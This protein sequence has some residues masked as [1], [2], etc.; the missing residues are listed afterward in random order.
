[1]KKTK[2]KPEAQPLKIYI[3]GSKEPVEC[4]SMFVVIGEST[5]QFESNSIR[6]FVMSVPTKHLMK[7]D[8]QEVLHFK[9]N[10]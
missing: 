10:I 8:E 9:R 5:Y 6:E 2:T 7:E 1:M 3:D 4:N